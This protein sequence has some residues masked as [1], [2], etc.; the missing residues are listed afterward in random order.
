[1][2]NPAALLPVAVVAVVLVG[3]TV[4]ARR[5]GCRLGTNTVV[6]CRD[7]HLFTT[8]WIP[9]ASFKSVRLGPYRR[10]YC[11]VGRHWAWVVPVRDADLTPEDR[12]RAEEHHD[13][14]VP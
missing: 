10:Q 1:M 7:G 8:I 9:G 4:V 12:Q 3:A 14:R 6:R 13:L 2:K 11:P 5:R